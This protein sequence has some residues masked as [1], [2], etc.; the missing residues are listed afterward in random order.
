[1]SQ[2]KKKPSKNKLKKKTPARSRKKFPALIAKYTT[3][4]RREF[5]D[6]DYIESLTEAEK[7]WLNKFTEEYLNAS[8]KNTSKDI[9]K[10]KKAKRQLYNK[11]NAVNR[12]IYGVG[13]VN[14]LLNYGTT[15]QLEYDTVSPEDSIIDYIDESRKK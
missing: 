10:S 6:M 13:K 12:D 2:P 7:E 9:H 8:F 3:K 11:N 15:D 1:M 4:V 14:K 5:L